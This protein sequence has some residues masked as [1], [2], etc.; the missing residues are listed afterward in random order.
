MSTLPKDELTI[1]LPAATDSAMPQDQEYFEIEANGRRRRIRFHDYAEIYAVPGL[2]ERLFA[3]TLCCRSPQ[4]V[5]DLLHQT[6][7]EH[8]H[9]PGDLRA[10]DFGAG[11]GMVGEELARI[12]TSSIVGLDELDEAKEAADRDR[13]GIY[14]AYHALDITEPEPDV[15][16]ELREADFN[17]LTCVA[18]LGFADIP[19]D[20]F[21]AALDLIS[22]DGW[23]AF[24]IRDRFVASDD[25][26]GFAD[27][28]DHMTASGELIQHAQL[29]YPHR[30]GI[31][32]EPLHYV[33]VVAQKSD[34]VP[35]PAG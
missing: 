17:C 7:L 19:P 15:Q 34:A 3:E 21:R 2:Y 6:L 33:A 16:S 12:G 28:L 26:S 27:L 14:D 25:P 18:A 13:P 11:N 24:N 5:V 1:H 10:V 9:D 30:L 31:S 22:P 8:Q 20:A 35:A 32:G 29:R 4:V 23:V